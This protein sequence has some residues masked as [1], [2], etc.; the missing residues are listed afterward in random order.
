MFIVCL[1]GRAG[2]LR[3]AKK[4]SIVCLFGRARKFKRK[5]KS[6]LLFV[7]LAWPGSLKERQKVVY[8]LFIRQGHKV[9]KK[10][11]KGFIVCLSGRARKLKRKA[12]GYL[13]F[14]YQAG[15]GRLKEAKS[16]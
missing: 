3:D 13:L 4:L 14:V 11:K 6:C 15:L 7:Y 2:N 5:A 12:K 16:C 1:S 10:G 8:C 9:Q